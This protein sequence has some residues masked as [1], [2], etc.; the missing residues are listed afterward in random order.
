MQGIRTHMDLSPNTLTCGHWRSAFAFRMQAF[1]KL[2]T[3][4]LRCIFVA[5]K[6]NQCTTVKINRLKDGVCKTSLCEVRQHCYRIAEMRT[7][8]EHNTLD[9]KNKAPN[10]HFYL[11]A[12]FLSEMFFFILLCYRETR[13]YAV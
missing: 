11:F 1:W 12:F 9:V 3:Q 6:L 10:D 5:L 2:Y 7:V 8:P 13:L 4:P